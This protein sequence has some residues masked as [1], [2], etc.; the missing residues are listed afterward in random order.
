VVL[1]GEN[2]IFH[3]ALLTKIQP[4]YRVELLR[5]ECGRI[6][7]VLFFGDIVLPLLLFMESPQSVNAPVD[8]KSET[9][10]GEPVSAVVE[11]RIHL[12][13]LNYSVK[14]RRSDTKSLVF[15]RQPEDENEPIVL[16]IL[17]TRKLSFFSIGKKKI[18]DKGDM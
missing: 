18:G 15:N 11:V 6:F 10:P 7:F 1:G 16:C 8:E 12:F 5:I 14:S 4:L 13:L 17:Y 3:A 9:F 2:Q